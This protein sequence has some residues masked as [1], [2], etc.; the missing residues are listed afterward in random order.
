MQATH[1]CM[2]LQSLADANTTLRE[3]ETPGNLIITSRHSA[4]H[5]GNN[6]NGSNIGDNDDLLNICD[7]IAHLFQNTK[8]LHHIQLPALQLKAPMMR[9]LIHGLAR[10]RNINISTSL[11]SLD[12]RNCETDDAGFELLVQALVVDDDDHMINSNTRGGRTLCLEH[13]ALPRLA[14][15]TR[16]ELDNFILSI[17]RMK[18]IKSI[19]FLQSIPLQKLDR[20]ADL[21]PSD[22]ANLL[23]HVVQENKQLSS[24]GNVMSRLKYGCGS[25]GELGL[26]CP[27]VVAHIKYYLKLNAF[28][29]HGLEND[30]D[31]DE[32]DNENSN[33]NNNIVPW[34]QQCGLRSSLWPV[35]LARMTTRSVNTDAL[36]YF[37]R[38][39]FRK[40]SYS[41]LSSRLSQQQQQQQQQNE[42][43]QPQQERGQ[44]G[45]PPPPSKKAKLEEFTNDCVVKSKR[46]TIP[47]GTSNFKS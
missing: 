3:L 36:F 39:Y 47:F 22:F 31:E 30:E 34:Q 24:L 19:D 20:G 35:I 12:M 14:N 29:R 38:E 28:G 15:D 26:Y 42:Q 16:I 37:I 46:V 25:A 7:A 10:V 45:A 9:H 5:N 40:N 4:N 27:R 2:I 8:S 6:H 41:P 33:N 18:R 44:Q 17:S 43:Q 11:K 32:E 23:L 21:S 1:Y 13:I